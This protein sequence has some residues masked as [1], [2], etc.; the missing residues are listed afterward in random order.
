MEGGKASMFTDQQ[1]EAECPEIHGKLT[2][3]TSHM[4]MPTCDNLNRYMVIMQHL[5]LDDVKRQHVC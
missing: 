1:F 3:G 2:K 4:G 5:S